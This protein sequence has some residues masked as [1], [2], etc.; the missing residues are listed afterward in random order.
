MD[1][2]FTRTF[3]NYPHDVV[4]VAEGFAVLVGGGVTILGHDLAPIAEIP[5][6]DADRPTRLTHLAD[7]RF[8]AREE[9]MS[10]LFVG[11]RD[12]ALRRVHPQHTFIYDTLTTAD[13]YLALAGDRAWLDRG[14]DGRWIDLVA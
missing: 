1:R 10:E 8:L 9:R 12:G 4:P 2:P 3:A 5:G 11:S 13:G 6:E 7:G 14:G